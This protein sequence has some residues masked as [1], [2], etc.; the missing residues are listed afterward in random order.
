MLKKIISI[1]LSA[2]FLITL[3]AP[4]TVANVATKYLYDKNGRLI[5]TNDF[6]GTVE[7]Q[8]DVKGNLVSRSKTNNLLVNS[9]FEIVTGTNGTADGWDKWNDT[10]TD[11]LQI[12]SSPVASGT[13]A[14]KIA[15]SDMKARG[16]IWALQ[17]IVVDQSKPFVL[18]GNIYVESLSN[19]KV[20][21]FIQF[22]D[23]NNDLIS[24][25]AVNYPQG[26][27]HRYTTLSMNDITPSNA[28]QARIHAGL[29]A[30]ADGG[31]GSFYVDSMSFRYQN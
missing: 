23:D 28:R 6:N 25:K 1:F 5:E 4:I 29:E 17:D 2:M 13:K 3:V 10:G 30:T 11:G 16:A 15:G 7:Y 21:L 22:F 19:A 31:A 14:Q 18:S 27:L 26:M 8:Y 9:S 12:V 24:S 20:S